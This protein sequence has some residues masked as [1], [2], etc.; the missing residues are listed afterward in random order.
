MVGFDAR[1]WLQGIA[2]AVAFVR[3]ADRLAE[4]RREVA[5]AYGATIKDVMVASTPNQDV[6]APIDNLIVAETANAK[7]V[8]QALADIAEAR[9]VLAGMRAVGPNER[10][11]ADVLECRYVELWSL[12]RV[13][14]LMMV[15]V[16]TVRR[17]VEYGID[18]LDAHGLAHA[19]AGAGVAEV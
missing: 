3:D 16:S 8:E 4:E 13:S 10:T 18:W 9:L 1:E 17:R 7:L 15:S 19:K 6:M 14:A 11:A 5:T 2:D 12:E